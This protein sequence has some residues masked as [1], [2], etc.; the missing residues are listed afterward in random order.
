METFSLSQHNSSLIHKRPQLP[1]GSDIS[2]QIVARQDVSEEEE[3]ESELRDET[4]L[5]SA[6]ELDSGRGLL[7]QHS[8][9]SSEHDDEFILNIF[10]ARDEHR[11]RGTLKIPMRVKIRRS[12][13]DVTVRLRSVVE[14][15]MLY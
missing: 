4:I 1:V 10:A 15:L 3:D 6:E 8:G 13:R 12:R 2:A 7:Y 11:R 9:S 14:W 5:S